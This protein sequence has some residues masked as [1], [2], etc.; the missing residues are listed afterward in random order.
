MKR[1]DP[2]VRFWRKV[3][4]PN[5]R[6]CRVWLASKNK[7]GYGSFVASRGRTV[8]AHRYAWMLA[9][10]DPGSQYVLHRCD[11]P[12]C[13]NIDHLFLGD[14]RANADDCAA[15]GRDEQK[16]KALARGR[17]A[18]RLRKEARWQRA[19]AIAEP[20]W[21]KPSHEWP[22]HRIASFLAEVGLPYSQKT[23]YNRLGNRE[24]A[25]RCPTN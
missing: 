22:V 5:S 3:G 8:Y 12:S 6:G 15:K 11:N 13:V 9:H 10:G 25:Q 18:V 21:R 4:S 14:H 23:L 19:K 16:R 1:T 2:E 7:S 24:G 20:L 17:E